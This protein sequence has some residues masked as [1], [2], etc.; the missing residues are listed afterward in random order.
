MESNNNSN[1]K[2]FQKYFKSLEPL[3][4][5]PKNR[6]YTAAIFSFLAISLFG[7]YA[8]RPTLN[9]I[10]LLRKEIEEKKAINSKLEKKIT[11]LIEAQ[12]NYQAIENELIALDQAIPGDP[13]VFDLTIQLKNLIAESESTMSAFSLANSI[14]IGGSRESAISKKAPKEQEFGMGIMLEGEYPQL[15]KMLTLLNTM[16]RLAATMSFS[17]TNAKNNA[18]NKISAGWLNMTLQLKSYYKQ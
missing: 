8:I 18:T 14:P 1:S 5:K 7:W 6:A 3:A 12:S 4:A 16:K 11:S 9:T 10:I 2:I 17:L 15:E 13:E